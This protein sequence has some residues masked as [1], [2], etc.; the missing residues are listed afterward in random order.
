MYIK[1]MKK[2]L[3]KENTISNA[4]LTETEQEQLFN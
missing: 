2:Q 1:R 3:K 4:N